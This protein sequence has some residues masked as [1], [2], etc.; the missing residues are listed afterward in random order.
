[1][2]CV[3]EQLAQVLRELAGPVD[4]RGARRDSLV[5]Q[6]ADGVAKERL[7]LG[8]AVRGLRRRRSPPAS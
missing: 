3:G 4:L 7:L 6:R 8:Q 1:M 2:S 5:G